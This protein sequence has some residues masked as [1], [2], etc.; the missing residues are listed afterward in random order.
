MSRTS[1]SLI[2]IIN[3]SI[4]KNDKNISRISRSERHYKVLRADVLVNPDVIK[5]NQS[6]RAAMPKRKRNINYAK[7][8]MNDPF[9]FNV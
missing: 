3:E 2:R 9:V 1:T 7:K 5:Y 6:Q 8:I 4:M